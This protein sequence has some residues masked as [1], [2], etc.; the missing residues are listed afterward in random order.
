MPSPNP[1]T[2]NDENSC[3]RLRNCSGAAAILRQ[4]TGNIHK[5]IA[6]DP[7]L[8]MEYV[9]PKLRTKTTNPTGQKTAKLGAARCQQQLLSQGGGIEG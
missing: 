6:Q 7:L 1:A 2:H 9:Q 5:H 4:Q 8:N 3:A